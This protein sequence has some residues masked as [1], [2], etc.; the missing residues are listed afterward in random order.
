MNAHKLSPDLAERLEQAGAAELLEVVVELHPAPTVPTDAPRAA[1]IAAARDAFSLA[2]SPVE[3]AINSV[4][5]EVVG[6][7]WINQ[8]VRARVPAGTVTG[9][10]DLD[11]VQLLDIPRQLTSDWG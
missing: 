6:T 2:S 1:R 8:T 4:G 3:Q 9:L 5:G 10:A 7:A 11:E